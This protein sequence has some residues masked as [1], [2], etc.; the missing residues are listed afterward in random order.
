MNGTQEGEQ[1]A[2]GVLRG[3]LDFSDID[4]E[5]VQ[6]DH[7]G[8]YSTRFDELMSDTEDSSNSHVPHFDEGE[9]EEEEGFL[10]SGKDAD[11]VGGYREQLR[12]VLGAEHEED[13]LDEQEVER[14][15][16][17][18]VEEKE[19]LAAMM[20][21]EAKVVIHSDHSPSRPSTPA[22]S[23]SDAGYPSTFGVVDGPS[24]TRVSL[25]FLHPTVSRLRSATPQGS[26]VPS[27]ASIGT[28][29]SHTQE[30]VS[31]TPSHFSS[32]SRNSTT[33]NIVVG[34]EKADGSKGQVYP[35]REV[36]RW[37]HLRSIGDHV[38]PKHTQKVSSLLGTDNAGSP[39]VIA[40][41]GLICVGTDAGK[42]LVFDF[43]QN[44]KCICGTDTSDR[45][46]GPVS[47]LALSFD[48]TYV[49]SG[50]ATG[51][52][53]LFDLKSPKLPV[54]L[55]APTSLTVIASGRQE[56]HLVGSR[57][58]NVGFVAGRHSAVVSADD[59]GL[60]FHHNLGKVFFMEAS[61]TLRLL[62]KYPDDE[63]IPN[64]SRPSSNPHFRRRKSRKPSTI[65]AMAPLP[66]G[67]ASHPT[68]QYNLI[69]LLTP[70]KLVIVGLKPSP[71]TW[72]RRHREADDTAH[73]SRFKGTLAWFPSVI[74]GST[75]AAEATNKKTQANG[76]SH[77]SATIP[78][79]VYSW[80]DTL[81]LIRV[82]EDKIVQQVRNARTGKVN[83]VETG[84]VI[85]EEV[86]QWSASD[87][88]LALQWLNVNQVL[89]LTPNALEVY[90]I[91]TGRLVEKVS[92]DAWSLVSPIL[93][94]TTTGSVSYSDTVTD[95]AH[96]VRVYKGKIF[97]MTQSEIQVGTLLTWADR[98]LSF[99]E[100]G[101][102]LS[103][104]ELTRSYYLGNTPG[105]R[106]GLPESPD[107]L[108]EVVGEK[109]RELMV[110]SARYAFSE[111]RMLD[112]THVTPDGR[113][114]D[115][116]SL[117]EGLVK[118]CARACIVL[119]DYDFLFEDLFQYFDDS[120]IVGIFLSQLEPFVLEG[121]IHHIPP[122]ITQRLIA[123]HDE[124]QHP[125]LAER[126]IWHI[127]PDCLDV[128]QAIALC[129]KHR[130]WDALIY[131]FTRAMKDYVSP[132]VELLG[133]IR[134][135]QQYRRARREGS[136]LMSYPNDN[137]IEP[138]ILNAYK[139]YPYLGNI[140][141]GLSYP[142]AEVLPEE[143]AIQAKNDVYNFLFFGRSSMWPP[144]EGGKLVLT[145]D[146]E[147]GVEPTYPYTR[148]LLR[149]DP[150][151]FLHT[152]DQAFE[153][154]YLNDETQG[155]SRLVIV[156]TLL[157][158][159]SSPDLSHEEVTFVNIFIARNV[160]KYPQF[161]QMP[162][163]AL[164]SILIGLAQDPDMDT[165]EDRQLAAEYLLSAYTPHE[166]DRVVALFEE[167]GFY[168]ILRSWYLQEH[169][170]SSLILTFMRDPELARSDILPAIDDT[171]SSAT[172][173]NKGSLPPDLL[174]TISDSLPS[175]VN[176][177]VASTA[178]LLD[179]HL[180]LLHERASE[181]AQQRG[182]RDQYIYLRYLLG[183]PSS[184]E[185]DRMVPFRASGPS[186]HVSVTLRRTYLSL[187]C[188]FDP[189]GVIS[190]LRYLPQDFLDVSSVAQ[191]CEEH[192]AYDA[193]VWSLNRAGDPFAALSK[194]E[195][196]ENLLSSQLADSLVNSSPAAES[197]IN[198]G[199][200]SLQAIGRTAGT[201]CLEHSQS[202]EV[203]LEDIWYQL[204]RS[205]IDAVQRIVG[206]FSHEQSEESQG[207][208]QGRDANLQQQTL[209]TLRSLV[210]ETFTSLLTVSST[211]S[212]SLPRMFKRLLTTASSQ[213][214][215]KPTLYAEFRALFTGMLE[216]Y[217]TDSD[218]LIITKH[219]ADRGLFETIQECSRE[220]DK[221]WAGSQGACRLC[222]EPFLDTKKSAT[223]ES[224]PNPG[225]SIIVS[226]T[227]AIYHSRCLPADHPNSSSVH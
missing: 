198:T 189:A 28:I 136:S 140:L 224:Q 40:A 19:K 225:N 183:P 94:H 70:I 155:V 54:R 193:V 27:S 82:S 65:L 39:T 179:K 55:V 110:A 29:P 84:R 144:G 75:A 112:G 86:R 80:G 73:K 138:V 115:L 211:K 195:Q 64:P 218:M 1:K 191:I 42:I 98:I 135:V 57:I 50:H 192:R 137:A 68:D 90:D 223:H 217:R 88:I 154:A 170:W 7:G 118:T 74:P 145:A 56:G 34:T 100:E 142:A 174:S 194:V 202:A 66:L 104:I 119:G 92:Y 43:K 125:D 149:F 130:L 51:H 128:D 151:A 13:E 52:V 212:V 79:L 91:R 81:F 60:A 16:L 133:L 122:R 159:L 87:D 204:L 30:G 12:D 177:S 8:D 113:G 176:T 153:D 32:L 172:Q 215:S 120:G 116:T 24:S 208:T 20:E 178:A 36:F 221:G 41:N 166:N 196:F 5:E 158:I 199:L 14:S 143:D 213:H 132:V 162:P 160:P 222:G 21:D 6:D 37:T 171:L 95:V 169:R 127:D 207:G 206:C 209:S 107:K 4:G 105:N 152:L 103:A 77:Q 48:H 26:R 203:P 185:D 85:L 139:I 35:I 184:G 46:V 186:V 173:S 18:D 114:V 76:S 89:G 44:L 49:A 216:S 200:S 175:L 106:N 163:S 187:S 62:G 71:R 168:R 23:H 197:S 226:R 157:E 97:I 164:H 156:K 15:L 11:P 126:I 148:L 102:F 190:A 59:N 72:Y 219:L 180:P 188:Q 227:G 17:H 117:F 181:L 210:H 150:E 147:S 182:D 31:V 9:E 123:L 109:M 25:S 83:N 58:V 63:H 53:Q 93:S 165:R 101:D 3:S 78:M 131:V 2:H 121:S 124:A 38:Y 61:D 47:A 96:S 69:A 141:S 111:D 214:V 33:T 134:N 201:M 10:Y 161:L 22:L 45:G 167:A 99:V 108:K 220:R 146:E 67:T 205:Q 129:Q